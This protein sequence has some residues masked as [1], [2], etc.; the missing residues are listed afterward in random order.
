ME[1][2]LSKIYE[3]AYSFQNH[4]LVQLLRDIIATY[5]DPLAAGYLQAPPINQAYFEKS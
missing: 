1:V 2:N 4:T 3:S 5:G